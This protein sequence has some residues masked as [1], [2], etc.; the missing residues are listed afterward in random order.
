VFKLL[1]AGDGDQRPLLDQRLRDPRFADRAFYVGLL[2]KDDLWGFYARLDALAVPSLTR[3][4]WMEQFGGVI[5]DAMAMGVPVVGSSSGAIPEVVGDAGV[6]VPEGDVEALAGALLRLRDDTRLRE[7]LAAAG[8]P[9][10]ER[11]F[12]I[13]AYA[14]RIARALQLRPREVH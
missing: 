13:P 3:P 9:R 5:A 11:E 7:R 4:T 14:A 8:P 6:I 10:F 12:A 2:R 1:L